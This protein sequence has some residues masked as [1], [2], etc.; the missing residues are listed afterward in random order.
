MVHQAAST[1]IGA[2]YLLTFFNTA[3]RNTS[4]MS[5]RQRVAHISTEHYAHLALGILYP[6]NG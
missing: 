4:G 1:A 3:L 5:W 6:L 2:V